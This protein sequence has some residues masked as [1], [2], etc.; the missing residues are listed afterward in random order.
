[1]T[2]KELREAMKSRNLA[3]TGDQRREASRRIFEQVE[4]SEAFTVARCVAVFCSLPDEPDTRDALER[5][6]RTRRVVVPR[7]EGEQ[8]HFYDYLPQE[9][10]TG[11]FGIAEPN[12]GAMLCDPVQI[13]L[14]VVP[15]TAFTA[16]GMRLG[17]GKG[18]YD[19][20]L[21]QHGMRA[22]KA[23]VCYAHQV[24]A[25]LP[26]EPHDVAMEAVYWG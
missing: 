24:V 11:A 22:A 26:S 8:I 14:V 7:V 2:K 20:Y 19:R 12:A 3:M 13:D 17:R 21:S 10:A 9:L 25:E 6:A 18:F 5:W 1:M 4:A 15:G 16:N 23:G